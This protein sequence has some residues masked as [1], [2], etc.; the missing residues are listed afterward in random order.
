MTLK[1]SL[2]APTAAQIAR[3]VSCGITPCRFIIHSRTEV[4]VAETRPHTGRLRASSVDSQHASRDSSGDLLC[5]KRFG[6]C[7]CS[8]R[9]QPQSPADVR[10]W[11]NALESALSRTCRR[12]AGGAD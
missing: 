12:R 6:V 2:A 11:R 9:R 1:L 8:E 7:E 4:A 5:C 3:V 10:L